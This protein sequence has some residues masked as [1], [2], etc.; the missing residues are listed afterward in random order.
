VNEEDELVE[1]DINKL[2]K[3]EEGMEKD[4]EECRFL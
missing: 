2:K 4:N 3:I 1:F